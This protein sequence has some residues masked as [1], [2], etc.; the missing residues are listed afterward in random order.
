M[1]GG[2]SRAAHYVAQ[3]R[4]SGEAVHFIDCGDGLFGHG[5]IPESA[6]PQ[7]ERK[8]KALTEAWKKMGLVARIA[9]PLDD[10]RGK[11]FHEALQLPELPEN[12]FR[13]FDGVAVVHASSLE[14]VRKH[15]P[16]ARAQGGR[17]VVAVVPR[18]LESLVR[19]ALEASDVDLVIASQSRDAFSAEENRLVGGTT[20]IAQIQSKGR[21]LLQ[22]QVSFSGDSPVQWLRGDGERDREVYGLEQRIELLRAQVNEPMLNETLKSLRKQK[23]EEVI[24]RRD[25]LA[26]VP[27]EI[28]KGKSTATAR[29]IPLESTTPQEPH[30]QAIE[31][32][33]D[34]DVGLINLAWAREHGVS[35]PPATAQQPGVVGSDV[36]V[37]CHAEAGMVWQASKHASAYAALETKGKNHHL[38]CVSC[39]VTGWQQPGGVCRID[40]T[41]GRRDV[42]CESCHGLGSAH[43]AKPSSTNITRSAGAKNCTS[44]HDRENSPQFEYESYLEK[45]R[46]PGHGR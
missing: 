16:Q 34:V 13:I 12:G 45:I 23:L 24:A 43:A 8:A 44:C 1:R 3:A 36:C 10:A 33:Y 5:S 19:E 28:P 31:Q 42:G 40:E 35:C 30:V 38:D 41:E 6:A 46:G 32:A 29:F 22:V 37:G 17:F 25:A 26:S 9:G 14:N 21:S 18:A 27:V 39:H 20:K 11:P 15:I 4:A 2:I 7:E